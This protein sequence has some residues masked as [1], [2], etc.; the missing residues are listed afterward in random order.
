MS[1]PCSTSTTRRVP[2]RPMAVD[3]ERQAL[4]FSLLTGL[5]LWELAGQLK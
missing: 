3:R 1:P 5:L 2:G 4:G